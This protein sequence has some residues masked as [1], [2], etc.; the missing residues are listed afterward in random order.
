MR[1]ADRSTRRRFCQA[2]LVSVLAGVAARL[3]AAAPAPKIQWAGDPLTTT[4]TMGS[5]VIPPLDTIVRWSREDH[6][7][8][9]GTRQILSLIQ[10]ERA[11]HAYPWTLYSQLTTQHTGGDA[12]VYY[13]RL[14]KQGPGW[15]AGFH[16][17][18]FNHARAV[19]LGANI[20]M[21]NFFQ[22]ESQII[23]MEM[24]ALGPEDCDCGIQIEG[25]GRF[26]TG[27]RVRCPGDT[28]I[29]VAGRY[30]VG[31]NLRENSIRLN[32]G[33]FIELDEKGEVRI[34]YFQ[35]NLEIYRGKQRVA[36]LPLD[37]ADR[38]L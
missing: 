37:G 32:E 21:S 8:T 2:S 26:R 34:R 3:D 31:L 17:E 18:L 9:P 5:P 28:G 16:S 25:K 27:I 15:S 23:G 24:Q 10:E 19:G 1:F 14:H 6:V 7:D 36:H 33:S 35:G 4:L 29:D 13:A 20:E 22:G 11:N 30:G 12:V 38:Q